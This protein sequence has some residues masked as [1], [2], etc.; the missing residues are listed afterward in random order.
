MI[1][2]W[3]EK[4]FLGTLPNYT[5]G[6]TDFPSAAGTDPVSHGPGNTGFISCLP[7]VPSMA[8]AFSQEAAMGLGSFSLTDNPA[9][10]TVTSP[11]ELQP[12]SHIH[13][14]TVVGK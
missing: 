2:R 12:K 5:P 9:D 7:F 13:N 1:Q 8:H 3:G 4:A 6:T 10:G 11:F 14:K